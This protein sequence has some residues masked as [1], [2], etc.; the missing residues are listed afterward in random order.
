M[1]VQ[2]TRNSTN[3]QTKIVETELT[4][5]N[6]SVLLF[7]SGRDID[8]SE[9]MEEQEE[10]IEETKGSN[11]AVVQLLWQGSSVSFVEPMYR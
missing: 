2:E 10:N 8:G 6:T 3:S 1:K 7:K 11:K 5:G 4:D 9:R